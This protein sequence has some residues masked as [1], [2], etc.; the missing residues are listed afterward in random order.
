MRRGRK[1]RIA[2][3]FQSVILEVRVFFRGGTQ[4]IGLAF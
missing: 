3:R 1:Y 4:S 2:N